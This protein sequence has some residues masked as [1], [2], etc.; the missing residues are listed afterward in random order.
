MNFNQWHIAWVFAFG[1]VAVVAVAGNILTIIIFLKRQL[2][3]RPHFLLINLAVADLLVGLLS[4][5]LHV[6]IWYVRDEYHNQVLLAITDWSDMLSGFAS[7]FT[8]AVISLER[9]Q[10]VGWPFH[11]RKLTDRAYAIAIATSWIIAFTAASTEIVLQHVVFQR[12]AFI[13]LLSICL[14]IPIMLTCAAYSVICIKVKSQHMAPR[15]VQE[16]RDLRLAKTVGLITG[17]FLLTWLPFNILFLVLNLCISCRYVSPVLA[18]IIKL[19]QYGNS[20]VNIAIYPIRDK[21]YREVLFRILSACAC[22]C[23]SREVNLSK[24]TRLSVIS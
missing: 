10:A 4:V 5:P 2:C 12:V 17:A 3:R 11:H 18:H 21:Q 7:I 9:M 13:I 14:S 16:A 15:H 8:L 24:E 20:V 1:V 22:S 19:L 23:R 6:I